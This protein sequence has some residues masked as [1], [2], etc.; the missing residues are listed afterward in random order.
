MR[1]VFVD[2]SYHV[3]LLDEGDSLH[4]K[5]VTFA[6]MKSWSFITTE[7]VLM[8]VANFYRRPGVRNQFVALDTRL[9]SS[10]TT[11]VLPSSPELYRAGLTLFAARPDKEWSLTDCTS[12]AVM[13]ERK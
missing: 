3:A 8:E 13:A 2:S 12:F 5:A 11:I 10:K 1:I 4:A 7:F 6:A 9:R